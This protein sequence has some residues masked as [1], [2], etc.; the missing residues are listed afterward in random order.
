MRILK[1][2]VL[3]PSS[4]QLNFMWKI[5]GDRGVAVFST[6]GRIR[7]ALAGTAAEGIVLAVR[8]IPVNDST[9]SEDRAVLTQNVSRPHLFKDAAYRPER[10]VRFVLKADPRQT[11]W[12]RGAMIRAD[13]KLIIDKIAISPHMPESEAFAINMLVAEKRSPSRTLFSPGAELVLS[14]SFIA[15][16]DLQ[17]GLFPDLD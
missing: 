14:S 8:Y 16:R 2:P 13:A 1:R 11:S 9:M 3:E 4:E 7:K 5:Y 12:T 15:E 17:V 6:V 10:E